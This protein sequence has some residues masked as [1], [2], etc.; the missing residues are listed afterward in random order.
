[1]IQLFPSCPE[2]VQGKMD[3]PLDGR[4]A[5]V[6]HDQEFQTV[7][8]RT[9]QDTAC[10]EAV[11]KGGQNS[12]RFGE[13]APEGHRQE[14]LHQVN[15]QK[16]HESSSAKSKKTKGGKRVSTSEVNASE[17]KEQN[18]AE[19]S[20]EKQK[21]FALGKTPFIFCKEAEQDHKKAGT[22]HNVK[23]GSAGKNGKTPLKKIPFSVEDGAKLPEAGK[24]SSS[25][26]PTGRKTKAGKKTLDGLLQKKS[27][28][29][30]MKGAFARNFSSFE[31]EDT[32][33]VHNPLNNEDRGKVLKFPG[34]GLDKK[35]G[36]A[37][38]KEKSGDLVLSLEDRRTLRPSDIP[39]LLKKSDR[40]EASP[41][42][43]LEFQG[44]RGQDFAEGLEGMA[45]QSDSGSDAGGLRF[46]L[47]NAEESKGAALLDRQLKSRGT[48]ELAKNIR[49]VLKD[50][51]QGEIKLILKP[52][53]LGKVR[54]NLNMQENHIVGRIIV[55]NNSVRQVFMNNLGEL[56]RALEESGY[57]SASLDVSVDSGKT[58]NGTFQGEEAPLRFAGHARQTMDEQIPLV[59]DGHDSFSQIDLVV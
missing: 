56:T 44:D 7:L 23:A 35:G 39:V 11:Y 53:A 21:A 45:Q 2:A 43:T 14:Q 34:T 18:F 52:E 13:D 58:G 27:G 32:A 3:R 36:K 31:Q 48:S 30:E 29:K 41:S 15:N 5:P 24:N 40:Q 38:G 55:E 4:A 28:E 8:E 49:F 9:S 17:K 12:S 51:N 6:H 42:L 20:E 22:D 26:N 10:R 25:D 37:K 33:K 1:M 57:N 16:S 19:L 50:N 46:T 54:I 59:Y 47:Q